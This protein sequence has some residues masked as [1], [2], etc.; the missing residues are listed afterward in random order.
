MEMG[1][2]LWLFKFDNKNE[3]ERVLRVG[4]RN[5]GGFSIFLK[6]WAKEDGC[7]IERF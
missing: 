5:L 1:K 2:G 6:K 7:E 3:A 4:I